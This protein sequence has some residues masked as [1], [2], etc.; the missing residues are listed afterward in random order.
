MK[1]LT[2]WIWWDVTDGSIHKNFNSLAAAKEELK[3][4]RA[5]YPDN[6][7]M[8]KEN[9]AYWKMHGKKMYITRVV[10]TTTFIS[11]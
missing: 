7:R 11:K 1:K 4:T 3:N 5:G 2:T 8:T 6:E 10:Q 9:R